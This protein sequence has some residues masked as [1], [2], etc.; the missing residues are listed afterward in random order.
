MKRT[1][2]SSWEVFDDD[3]HLVGDVDRSGKQFVALPLGYE[4]IGPYKSLGAAARA[5]VNFELNRRVRA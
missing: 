4:P 2:P 5:L 1:R 3:G